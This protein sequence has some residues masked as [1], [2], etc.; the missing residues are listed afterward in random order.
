VGIFLKPKDAPEHLAGR[1]VD[2]GMEDEAGAA[3]L[4]PGVLAAVHLDEEAGLGHA[5]AAAAMP[6]GATGAG[7]ADPGRT[8]EPLH[9]PTRHPEALALGQQLGEVVV[10]HRCVDRAG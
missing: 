2:R 10:I 7:T 4:Q 6:R 1:I 5:F 3:V 9:S 8:E